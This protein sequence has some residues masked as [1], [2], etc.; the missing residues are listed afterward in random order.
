MKEIPR[1]WVNV[2]NVIGRGS[3]GEVCRAVL[4]PDTSSSGINVAV[5]I[6]NVPSELLKHKAMLL[7]ETMIMAGLS[8]PHVLGLIG[9][10]TRGDPMMVVLEYCEYGNL[11][12]YVRGPSIHSFTQARL[13]ADVA[14]GMS[15]L[16]S[17]GIVHRDLS[18]YH[19]LVG[20]EHRAR[21]SNYGMSRILSN[22]E[23]YRSDSGVK[24]IRWASP[25]SLE[26][27]IFSEATDVWSFGIVMYEIWSRGQMPYAGMTERMVWAEVMRGFRLSCPGDCSLEVYAMMKL[28]WGRPNERPVFAGLRSFLRAIEQKLTTSASSSLPDATTTAAPASPAPAVSRVSEV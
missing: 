15:F 23:Y 22:K 26:Q 21:I 20:T 19:V 5:K 7:H 2:S 6:L 16:H 27:R 17:R 11:A 4:K 10:V 13:S 18:G 25:E 9:V 3:F 12:A 8:H 14:D 1:H 24:S 28:C